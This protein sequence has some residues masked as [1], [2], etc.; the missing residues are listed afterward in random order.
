MCSKRMGKGTMHAGAGAVIWKRQL[1]LSLYLNTYGVQVT[2][3]AS[4]ET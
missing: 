4:I 2:T 3:K 1:V